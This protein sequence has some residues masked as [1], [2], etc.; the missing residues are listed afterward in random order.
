[1]LQHLPQSFYMKLLDKENF[2][3]IIFVDNHLLV[4]EKP[5]NMST[6]LTNNQSTSLEEFLK[7]W[8]KEKFNKKNVFLHP[9]HRLD[10][11]TSGLVIFARS[12]KALSRLNKQMRERKIIKKYIAQIEGFLDIKKGDLKD[13]ILHLS[14]RAKIVKNAQKNA[15]LAHLSYKVIKE[16]ESTSLVEITLLTGRYHQI[17]AQFAN[18]G[19]NVVGDIKYQSQKKINSLKNQKAQLKK[20]IN[21]QRSKKI[22]LCCYFLEFMHPIQKDEKSKQVLKFQIKPSFS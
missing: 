20:T 18:L 16:K 21:K 11:E 5:S 13:Y 17:R 8:I 6:Q 4:V 14:H 9:I 10:T 22:N 15:K 2:L 7:K 12:S 19:H 1:M 3:N